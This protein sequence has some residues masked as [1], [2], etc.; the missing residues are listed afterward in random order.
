ME[1]VVMR[2]AIAGAGAVGCHYG[3]LLSQGGHDVVFLARGKHLAA[4]QVNGLHHVSMDEEHV[5][6]V[7]AGNSPSLLEQAEVILLTCKMTDLGGML[8]EIRAHVPADALLVTLQ[9][10]VQA[11][12]M[13][14]EAFPE[15]AVAAG[16]AFIG[17]RLEAPGI[18]VHSAAGDVQLGLWRQ[19][20][21]MQYLSPFQAALRESGIPVHEDGDMRL[22][23]WRKMVWNCGF[24]PITALTRR[25][26]RDIATHPDTRV[27]VRD[28]MQEVVQV[29][30]AEGVALS[31]ADA[32][33][34][35]RTTQAMGTVKT[36][37]WQDIERQRPTE[38]DALNGYV[39]E[40]SGRHGI[41]APV[42]RT[43]SVLVRALEGR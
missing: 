13:V 6:S 10:G 29:A 3:S 40:L 36:S 9:N 34:H 35:I 42:N 18:V 17:V 15:H 8:Q 2:I 38:I 4:M 30:Q 28:A 22:T 24:N 7:N 39:T 41:E 27:I 12:D 19:D 43:L 33:R 5:L 1:D 25:Y 32:E 26:A 21:G 11:P 14:A 23:M 20:A 16:T 37:M 31:D